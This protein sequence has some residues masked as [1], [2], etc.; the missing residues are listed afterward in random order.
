VRDEDSRVMK[1]RLGMERERAWVREGTGGMEREWDEIF[2]GFNNKKS[3]N[4]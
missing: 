3:L 2:L 4:K 1:N